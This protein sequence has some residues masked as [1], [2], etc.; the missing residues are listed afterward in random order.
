MLFGPG[1]IDLGFSAEAVM[2]AYWMALN[3]AVG[4]VLLTG[5]CLL[6]GFMKTRMK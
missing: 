5:M 1:G 3:A 6:L 4:E 2:P